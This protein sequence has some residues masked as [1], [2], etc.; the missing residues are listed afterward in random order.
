MRNTPLAWG[1]KARLVQVEDSLHA[2]L[3][4]TGLFEDH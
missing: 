2:G 3:T 4:C 1:S